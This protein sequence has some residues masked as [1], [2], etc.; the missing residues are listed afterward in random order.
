MI[1]NNTEYI[2]CAAIWYDDGTFHKENACPNINSGIVV[3]G[4]RHYNCISIMPT[5]KDY[6]KDFPERNIFN[7]GD[8]ESTQGFMTSKGRFV[9]RREGMKLAF[10]AGQVSFMRA[11]CERANEDNHDFWQ[12]VDEDIINREFINWSV[13]QRKLI[14][15]CVEVWNKLYSEDLY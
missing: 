5:G 9:D 6:L 15:D 2:L 12:R 8:F 3:T 10:I 13:A 11:V 14:A 1:D 7:L 4:H